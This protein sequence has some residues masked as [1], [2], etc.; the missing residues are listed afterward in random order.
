M[1]MIYAYAYVYAH[2]G[3]LLCGLGGLGRLQP[4]RIGRVRGGLPAALGRARGR[5]VAAWRLHLFVATAG[6]VRPRLVTK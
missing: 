1:H 3:A 4:A 2:I 6:G 5:R